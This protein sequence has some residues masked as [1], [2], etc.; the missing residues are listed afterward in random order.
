[1]SKANW[2]WKERELTRAIR[3]TRKAGVEDFVARATPT[4]A[5]EIAISASIK[6][7]SPASP[8]NEWDDAA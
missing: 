7:E 1:M 5:I 6:K 8:T 3:A 2:K 4:G